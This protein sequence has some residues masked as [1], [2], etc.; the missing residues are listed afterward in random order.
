MEGRVCEEPKPLY[1]GIDASQGKMAGYSLPL[2]PDRPWKSAIQTVYSGIDAPRSKMAGYPHPL[3]PDRPCKSAMQTVYSGIDAS[4]ELEMAIY[5]EASDPAIQRVQGPSSQGEMGG[6]SELHQVKEGGSRLQGASSQGEM[7]GGVYEL[8]QVNKEG[9]SSRRLYGG[10]QVM[11]EGLFSDGPLKNEMHTPYNG[12]DTSELEM[13]S[14]IKSGRVYGPEVRIERSPFGLFLDGHRKREMD[15]NINLFMGFCIHKWDRKG[16][17]MTCSIKQ[18]LSCNLY[19]RSVIFGCESNTMDGA[20]Q[21]F[22]RYEPHLVKEGDLVLKEGASIGR[23]PQVMIAGSWKGKMH[24]SYNGIDTSE[25]EMASSIKSDRAYVPQVRIDRSP[26]GLF[27]DGLLKR[28]MTVSQEE[29][30]GCPVPFK[31][32]ENSS[33]SLQLQVAAYRFH[34]MDRKLPFA[35]IA[36]EFYEKSQDAEFEIVEAHYLKCAKL[37]PP[38]SDICTRWCHVSF[39]A[40]PKNAD[41]SNVSPK[42]LFAELFED[43]D[44]YKKMTAAYCSSFEPSDDPGFDHGCIFCPPGQ[45]FHPADGYKVG[46]HPW[47]VYVEPKTVCC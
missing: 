32:D 31:Y 7:G 27:M 26:F 37:Y 41:C 46:S 25:L 9:S 5:S 34:F 43:N 15:I 39:V 33:A 16:Q 21:I 29:M 44:N 22:G 20:P 6:G 8:H 36:L 13:A 23:V 1:S 4:S 40:K 14:S 3:Y 30:A 18:N 10:P 12:V 45:K 17:S 24:T 35:K 2:D 38:G 19:L 28:E 47:R 42:H 11:I